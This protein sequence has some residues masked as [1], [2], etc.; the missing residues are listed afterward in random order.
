MNVVDIAEGQPRQRVIV[1]VFIARAGDLP[2]SMSERLNHLVAHSCQLGPRIDDVHLGLAASWVL[3]VALGHRQSI[4]SL[5]DGLDHLLISSAHV[6][7]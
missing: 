4:Q 2:T 1:H 3:K 7:K 5:S 6:S